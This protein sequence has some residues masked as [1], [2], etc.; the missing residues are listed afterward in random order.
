MQIAFISTYPP[1]A[2]GIAAYTHALAAGLESIDPT[3]GID[4]ITEKDARPVADA[5]VW[6]TFDRD[7]DYVASILGRVEDIDPD[8]VHIQ[9]EYGVFGLDDRFHALLAGLRRHRRRVVVT[10]HTVH[11]R[12]SIDLGCSWR[13]RRPPLADLDIEAYQRQ[14]GATADAVVVHQEEPIRQVLRR[15]GLADDRVATIP[16]GTP[17][18]VAPTKAGARAA[19]GIPHDQSVLLGFGYFEPAKN[20]AVLIE[21][22]SRLTERVPSA[23]LL[24]G[25][26]VRHPVPATT[27]Y[28]AHCERV[29]EQ[30]GLGRAVSFLDDPVP[31]DEVVTLFAA[32]DIACFVY[33]EDTRSSSGALHWAVGCGTPVMASRI[34]KFAE[35][36]RIS[37]ELLVNPRSPG[38]VARL[39]DRLL[40]DQAFRDEVRRRGGS[41][42]EETSWQRVAHRHLELYR[43]VTTQGASRRRMPVQ[44]PERRTAAAIA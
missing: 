38:E 37:D 35:V 36:S 19:L 2:C 6:P 20:H 14:V 16:H 11:T 4:V 40:S 3:L 12:L 23:R 39:A 33:D 41:F 21:A 9:H 31:D 24:I 13:G 27:A 18:V 1:A 7:E 5:H 22:L 8:L 44:L 15:Q 42:A 26:Y 10:L 28:R 29:V 32:A 34:A 43:D 30:F 25:G 17:S